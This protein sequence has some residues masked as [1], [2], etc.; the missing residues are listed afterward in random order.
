MYSTIQE[1]LRMIRKEQDDSVSLDLILALL[2]Q[3]RR[4]S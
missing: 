1:Q 4:V 3:R 2:E